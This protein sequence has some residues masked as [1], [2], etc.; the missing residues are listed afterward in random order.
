VELTNTTHFEVDVRSP[1]T[2][3]PK[4]GLP[5]GRYEDTITVV[6]DGEANYATATAK[7]TFTV[8]TPSSSTP[9]DPGDGYTKTPITVA[10]SANITSVAVNNS[11]VTI[12]YSDGSTATYSTLT[13]QINVTYPANKL[14]VSAASAA[15]GGS[16][17]ATGSGT[18][19]PNGASVRVIAKAVAASTGVTVGQE[20]TL[21]GTVT[22]SDGKT[23]VTIPLGTLKAGTYD[24]E[25][26]SAV[27]AN[28]YF[29]APL[30]KSFQVTGGTTETPETPE[31]PEAPETPEVPT[32]PE[33]PGKAPV[34]VPNPGTIRS[35]VLNPNGAVTITYADGTTGTYNTSTQQINITYPKEVFAS[36]AS[37]G[38]SVTFTGTGTLIPNGTSV[39]VIV[40]ALA[41]SASMRTLAGQNYVL[42]STVSV[43][44]G[45]T[46]IPVDLAS[47]ENGVYSL[48]LES[49][50]SANPYFTAPLIET[51][52]VQAGSGENDPAKSGGGGGCDTG[53]AGAALLL[54]ASLLAARKAGK[55]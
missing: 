37:G 26:R 15:A 22:V 3:R 53:F 38:T 30:G 19:I 36:S 42:E 55:R 14:T 13:Q 31:T 16:L 44:G 41:S 17:S 21:T 40:T 48:A 32:T 49:Q 54:T 34:S 47:V 28:P 52:R 24:L 8:Y 2:V 51:F 29:V 23:T 5:S 43:A 9:T 20:F 45:K 46:A 10:T 39:R 4:A 27:G 50:L 6:F 35:V 11:A 18:L 12:T 1:W 33:T 25:L 7:V